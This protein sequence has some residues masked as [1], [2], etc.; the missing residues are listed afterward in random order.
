[1]IGLSTEDRIVVQSWSG[2]SVSI[3]GPIV[4]PSTWTHI[5]T[6]YSMIKGMRLWVD[7]RLEN[8]T[9][10]FSYLASSTSNWITLGMTPPLASTCARGNISIGQF[11]GSIDEFMVY[12]IE[13]QADYISRIANP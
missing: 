11:Y 7:G 4:K 1:M 2:R 13:L 9:G 10:P 5:V 3:V 6:T 8:S 12:S